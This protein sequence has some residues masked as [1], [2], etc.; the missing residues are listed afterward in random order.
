VSN[1]IWHVG[2]TVTTADPK[3]CNNGTK[4]APHPLVT[5]LIT[6]TSAI[7]MLCWV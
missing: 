3:P 1:V 6:M 4:Q 2:H 7:I 5:V